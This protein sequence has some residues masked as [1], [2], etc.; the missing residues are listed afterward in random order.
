MTERIFCAVWVD[1]GVDKFDVTYRLCLALGGTRLSSCHPDTYSIL[2][3]DSPSYGDI[4][5]RGTCDLVVAVMSYRGMS[6][7][8]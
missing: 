4:E 8:Q 1:R 2:F 6:F 7:I 3:G 5:E